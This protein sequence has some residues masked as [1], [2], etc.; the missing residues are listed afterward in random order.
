[1]RILFVIAISEERFKCI[2]DIGQGYLA[3]IARAGGHEVRLLDCLLER[4]DYRNFQQYVKDYQPDVVGIKVYSCDIANVDKMLRMAREAVPVT[5]TVIGGPHPSC[6]LPDRLFEQFPELDY[7]FAGEAELGFLP[8]LERIESHETD[9]TDIPGLVWR[10][11]DGTVRANPKGRVDDLD[12]L[13]FPAWDLIDPRRYK[14]GYSFATSKFPAAP[15]VMTRGCPYSCT[16]CSSH[17]ISGKRVRKRSIDNIVEE[18]NLLKRDFGVRS[19]DIADENFALDRGFVGA[20]CERLLSDNIAI[21]WNCPHGVRIDN[22]DEEIVRLMA[23]SGCFNLSVGV[24]SGSQRVL[25]S[26]KKG[27]KV[28]DVI[29]KVRMI[30]R[31]SR[32]K[33]QG[34][35]V[36]GFPAETPEDIEATIKLACSLPFDM[37]T[38]CPLRI[39]PG[40]EIYDELLAAGKRAADLD[41]QGF[42][43]YYFVRSYCSIPDDEMR[44]LYRKAYA[45]FY[46][47]PRVALNLLRQ[48]RSVGQFRLILDG[49]LRMVR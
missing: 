17:L 3:T 43:H 4:Y 15:M 29:E 47:R 14:W 1:M 8:F 6:E 25:D 24:E 35:F 11:T 30:K 7:A 37:V 49:L 34:Y 32:M 13:A 28:E 48:V 42:G 38:F 20:F 26:I 12:S 31:V 45:Q 19:I 33:L 18:I 10:Y 36:V 5:V 21:A 2:P 16:F 41:Y 27:V 44:R 22:L 9:M 23:R 39:T 40:T 46:F